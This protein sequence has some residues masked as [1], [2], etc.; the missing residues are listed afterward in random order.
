[1]PKQISK[2]IGVMLLDEEVEAWQALEAYVLKKQKVVPARLDQKKVGT[3]EL[4]RELLRMVTEQL[5]S[6][7]GPEFAQKLSSPR[8]VSDFIMRR[9]AAQQKSKSV[10]SVAK[11][12]GRKP[13]KKAPQK[14]ARRIR[15]DRPWTPPPGEAE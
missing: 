4:L 1:M 14:T 5:A 10:P 7:I 11:T 12:R 8:R 6:E 13:A 15:W 3:R 9:R 2:A